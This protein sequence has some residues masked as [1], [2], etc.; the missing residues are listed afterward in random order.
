M[1]TTLVNSLKNSTELSIF[2]YFMNNPSSY[3]GIRTIISYLFTLGVNSVECERVFS[4]M[5]L[6]K[7]KLRTNMNI[8][9]L[10]DHLNVSL[11]FGMIG[12][13]DEQFIRESYTL[14]KNASNRYFN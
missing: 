11:N 9:T 3:P 1:K 10:Y 6:I 14:W 8:S 5:N 4:K 2:E 13:S 7:S 12:L